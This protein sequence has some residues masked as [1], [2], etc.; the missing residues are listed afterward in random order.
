MK[1]HNPTA[2]KRA[3]E[4]THNAFGCLETQLE[5]PFAQ[6]ARVRHS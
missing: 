1:H 4:N 5:K 6:G 3:V 2:D